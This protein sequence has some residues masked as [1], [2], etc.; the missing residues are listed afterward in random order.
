MTGRIAGF[1][2]G[3]LIAIPAMGGESLQGADRL[4]CT[5][6]AISH[7]VIGGE[8][9]SGAP[10]SVNVPSFIEI[11][12]K[13][14]TLSTT[15]ASGEDRST[16]VQHRIRKDGHIY[17]LGVELGRAFVITIAEA[18]GDMVLMV[19]TDSQTGTMFGACTPD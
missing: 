7:C 4:L 5:P 1:F 18:T 12:L 17:L 14:K 16:T 8:C 10:A 6:G 13:G 11:D 2:L 3:I 9:K 15:Q 19:G